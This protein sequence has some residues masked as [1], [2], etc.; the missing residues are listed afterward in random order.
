MARGPTSDDTFSL[1]VKGAAAHVKA[2]AKHVTIGDS[3][4]TLTQMQQSMQ[5]GTH[6]LCKNPDGSR[7]YYTL[8]AERS[9][10]SN[11]VLRPV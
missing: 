11:P 4:A 10:P 9:T 1:A 6:I 3:S 5:T 2:G 8:D 7:S